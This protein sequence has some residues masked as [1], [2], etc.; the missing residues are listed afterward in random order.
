ML[1]QE[2]DAGSCL[3]CSNILA[4]EIVRRQEIADPGDSEELGAKSGAKRKFL[5]CMLKLTNPGHGEE[6]SQELTQK[7]KQVPA[8]H[9]QIPERAA[10]PGTLLEHPRQTRHQDRLQPRPPHEVM[11]A[12]R[13]IS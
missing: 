10:A 5:P 6:P 8:S 13:I 7:L 1:N 12:K 11:K 3:A 2:L 9:A 4:Q